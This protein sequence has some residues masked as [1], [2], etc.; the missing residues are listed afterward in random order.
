MNKANQST[1]RF[2]QNATA[3]KLLF[4]AVISIALCSFGPLALFAPVPLSV[5]FLLYG[6]PLAF[7]IGAV[8]TA[9]L[10]GV[11]LSVK[12]FPPMFGGLYLAAFLYAWCVAEIVFRNINPVRGLTFGGL[13]LVLLS[14]SSII[15]YDKLSPVSLKK[16][17]HSQTA[18]L[19]QDLKKQQ[20]ST[21]G[22]TGKE[23]MEFENL[24]EHPEKLA[25]EIYNTL[26][27]IVFVFSFFGLWIT[28]FVTL[29]NS[30]IWRY[31][32]QYNFN[33]ADL[34][35]FRAPDFFVWPLIVSLVMVIGADYGMPAGFETIGT[36]L[37][38][39]LG[40][41]YLFQGFGVYN[42]F[43]KFI[44]IGG[45]VKVLFLVFTLFMGYKFLALLGLFDLWFDF[46]KFFTKTKK[47]EGDIL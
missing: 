39:C 41:F 38:Y 9:V 17:I 47:D 22:L 11:S 16:E 15:A 46:R 34:L 13:I 19:M 18:K 42:D 43:L 5:A 36:N 45:F 28:L 40:V 4:L 6:R 10:W 23:A 35:R 8:S 14:A 32:V 37:L 27:S 44:R 7:I 3:G 21:P 20:K 24:V 12:G 1:A 26:P 30:I 33:S 29:R 31:R 2:D 25:N